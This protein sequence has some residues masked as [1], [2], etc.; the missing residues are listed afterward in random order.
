MDV[1]AGLRE[2]GSKFFVSSG[3]QK[4]D[5]RKELL[6]RVQGR[7]ESDRKVVM[8]INLSKTEIRAILRCIN[9]EREVWIFRRGFGSPNADEKR[10][11]ALE[12]KLEKSLKSL[13]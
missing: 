8:Q 3:F 9:M 5:R 12:K 7:I 4:Q 6:R 11:G 1:S 10:L 13:A 2:R